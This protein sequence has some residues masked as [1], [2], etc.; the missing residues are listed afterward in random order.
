MKTVVHTVGQE[1]RQTKGWWGANRWLVL[2]RVSQFSI[3]ALFLAGPWFG[4]WL[5]KGNLNY[6]L[7]LNTVPLADP[8]VMLQSLLARHVPERN[9]IIGV[10]LVLLF[11]MLVGGRSFCAWVCPVNIVTDCASAMRRKLDIR[12]GGDMPR[13]TRYWIL[14]LILVL[15]ASTGSI[16]WEL[17]NPVSLLPRGL[18]FGM[19]A[20]WLLIA[21]IFLF[22]LFVMK[23]AWCSHLCPVGAFYSTLGKW[24][25]VRVAA[26]KREACNDCLDCYA[27]C[28]EQQVIRMPLKGAAKGSSPVILSPNCTNCGRCIDVCSKDVFAFG[29]RFAPKPSA[30]PGANLP[31]Q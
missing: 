2:R 22:D 14:A 19:G 15:A 27:V 10:S 23:R 24:S 8:L 1:A 16:V 6:S 18:L 21:A 12:G 4:W 28:P 17:V 5:V 25:L 20:G 26:I 9:A 7:T 11:Y 3:L 30:S 13:Q 31:P 29:T